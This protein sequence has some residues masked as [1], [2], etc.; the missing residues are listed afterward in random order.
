MALF[1]DWRRL[2]GCI[3][4]QRAY[5]HPC[6]RH[7]CCCELRCFANEQ[8]AAS[9]ISVD[10]LERILTTVSNITAVKTRVPD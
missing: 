10:G 3:I 8:N 1:D 6:I 2:D 9:C 7:T 5:G 4:Y